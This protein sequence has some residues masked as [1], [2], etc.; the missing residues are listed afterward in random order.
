[1]KSFVVILLIFILTAIFVDMSFAFSTLVI[2]VPFGIAK[3]LSRKK[4]PDHKPW[5][6]SLRL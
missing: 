4:D 2:T 5:W 3:S 1:M 6:C